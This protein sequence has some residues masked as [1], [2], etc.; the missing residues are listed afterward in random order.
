MTALDG[1]AA[2]LTPPLLTTRDRFDGPVTARATLLVFAAH[3]TPASHALGAVLERARE[4]H[5]VAWRHFPD[6]AAHPR[7]LTF[8]L[9][10]EAAAQ[11]GKFWALTRAMLRLRHF[12]SEDLHDAMLR[13]GLDPERT[14]EAMQA[15]VGA[16]RIAEDVASARASGVEFVPTLFVNGERYRGPLATDAVAAALA[17]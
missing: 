9:A 11:R 8:A 5:L 14:L 7:A 13:A 10:A 12:D 17:A 4:R 6:P 15:G 1:A 3:A 16:D 2:R